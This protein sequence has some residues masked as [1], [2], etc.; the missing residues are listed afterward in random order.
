MYSPPPLRRA[1]L[2]LYPQ[3][4]SNPAPPLLST[5][6]LFLDALEGAATVSSS[7]SSLPLQTDSR[8]AP[9]TGETLWAS[10]CCCMIGAGA[11]SSEG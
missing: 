5:P 4:A 2:P 9:L 10:G 1:S 11:V 6:P 8:S 3:P 7:S